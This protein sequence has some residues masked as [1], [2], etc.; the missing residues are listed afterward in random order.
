[1]QHLQ[2][3]MGAFD[4]H[5]RERARERDT[6]L[7]ES[8][9]FYLGLLQKPWGKARGFRALRLTLLLALAQAANVCGFVFA[10]LRAAT[11]RIRG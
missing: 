7:P 10:G 4:Y 3:G 9:R 5:Q 1:M 2:Y 11:A 6:L 8:A